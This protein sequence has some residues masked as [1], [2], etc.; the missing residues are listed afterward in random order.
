MCA[1]VPQALVAGRGESQRPP[2]EALLVWPQGPSGQ[3]MSAQEFPP[4]PHFPIFTHFPPF[5]VN[6]KR[7]LLPRTCVYSIIL[8]STIICTFYIYFYMC[9]CV[10]VYV[11]AQNETGNLLMMS[12]LDPSISCGPGA[13]PATPPPSPAPPHPTRSLRK[14]LQRHIQ[15]HRLTE[16]IKYYFQTREPSPLP[17]PRAGVLEPN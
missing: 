7:G 15:V 12:P 11:Y 3:P 14:C 10:C 9:V 8:Y 4:P 13:P 17:T 16:Q 6:G 2:V 5:V 1:P